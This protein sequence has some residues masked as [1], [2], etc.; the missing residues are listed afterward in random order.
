MVQRKL[1]SVNGFWRVLGIRFSLPVYTEAGLKAMVRAQPKSSQPVTEQQDRCYF[2]TQ[3]PD[4][5]GRGNALLESG[6]RNW[7]GERFEI[8]PYPYG[9]VWPGLDGHELW[10]GDVESSRYYWRRVRLFGISYRCGLIYH[11]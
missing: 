3:A 8:V 1:P 9:R 6:R 2:P 10:Y 5:F 7:Y 11:P 4:P